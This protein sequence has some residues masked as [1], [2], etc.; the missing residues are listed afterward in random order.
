[1]DFLLLHLSFALVK[2][3]EH[4]DVLLHIEN[5]ASPFGD[6]DSCLLL[7]D[8]HLASR[9]FHHVSVLLLPLVLHFAVQV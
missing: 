5:F 3:F 1:M 6:D 7:A 4:L 2:F 9:V 8:C